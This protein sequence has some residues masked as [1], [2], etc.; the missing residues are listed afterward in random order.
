[1]SWRDLRFVV[2]GTI[3]CGI[4]FWG[5]F[6][7]AQQTIGSIERLEPEFDKLVTA[8]T[9]IE[10]IGKGFTWTEGPVWMGGADGHLLFTDIPR[11]SIFKYQPGAESGREISL[12][13]HPSGYT[14]VAFYGYEPGSNGLF[15]DKQ[16]RLCMCEH[17]DR[18]VSALTPG[19]GKITLADKFDGKR[20]NSPNDAVVMSNGDIYFTDPPYG[21][22]AGFEDPR[23]E[24]DFC[25]VYRIKPSGDIALMT[26]SIERPNGIG[27]S[28][29]EKH[30]YVAQSNPKQ[31]N[32]T[33]F[34]VK[35]DGTLGESIVLFDATD[36]VGKEPGLPDGLEVDS[37][38]NLWASGPGGIYVFNPDGKLLGRLATGERTSN[39]TIAPAG[40]LYMTVDHYLCRA[41]VNVSP[42][43]R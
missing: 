25:G 16:G 41:K 36:R 1:M 6:A 29:D 18:R 13:M 22:P 33:R 37:Q 39:C 31:A 8:E 26:S 28:P 14:G 9:K 10:V 24:Q 42:I 43:R 20:L 27:L 11:N 23:R 38:G 15:V 3:T 30:L 19:G 32:W 5:P 40:W 35:A 2:L 17:G 7:T 34:E 21:L 12:F 4:S